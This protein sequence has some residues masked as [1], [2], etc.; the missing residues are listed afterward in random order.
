MTPWRV[1]RC[2]P[3][4][5]LDAV[6]LEIKDSEADHAGEICFVVEGALYG[7]ALYHGQSPRDRAIEVFS[8]L[9]LWDTNH[10]NAVLIYVLLADRAVELVADRGAHLKIRADDWQD[11]CRTMQA[12]FAVGRYR[13]GA[14]MGIRAVAKHLCAHFPVSASA[15]GAPAAGDCDSSKDIE[16]IEH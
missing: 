6:E 14:L 10:R 3:R 8:R 5:T 12:S 1:R 16:C 4:A 15:A 11:I 9:R 7:A 2:F 13:R